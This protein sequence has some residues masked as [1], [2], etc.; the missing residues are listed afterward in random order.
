MKRMLPE[1]APQWGVML[2][3]PHGGTD[4]AGWLPEIER[5]YGEL[6]R[7]ITARENL[8]IIASDAG[9]GSVIQ[10]VIDRAG[11]LDERVRLAF[12][13]SDDTWAR[14]H[15]PIAV[16]S[17]EEG[18]VLKNFVFNGWGGKWPAYNDDQINRHLEEFGSLAVPLDGVPFVMEG[19][20]LETDGQGTIMTT[21][22]CLLS[23]KRNPGLDEPGVENMLFDHLGATR[24]LWLSHGYLE[25][26]DTDSHIDTLARFADERTIVFQA[27]DDEN[28]SHFGELAA[29]RAELKG[30][31]TADGEPY[32]LLELPWPQPQH[33]PETDKRLP[34]SYANFLIINDAVLAPSYD[35]PADEKARE[36]L[37]EA[38]PDREIVMIDCRPVIRGFGSLHCLTMQLPEGAMVED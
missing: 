15:G 27:C 12:A 32:R 23:P 30:F 31:R 5:V 14:D 25:G 36:V 19:G 6:A 29:M 18:L 24:V 8:L 20:A 11:G 28:D 17:D 3:W 37:A 16:E 2:T 33:D 34:A 38:F 26:D 13:P 1:W 9:H 21:R 4:W 10:S 35:D 22:R 7:E